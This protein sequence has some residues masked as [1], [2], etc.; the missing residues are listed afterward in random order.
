M[1]WNWRKRI[2]LGPFRINLSK[3][4]LGYSVGVPGFRVGKDAVGRDYTQTSIPGSG[5]YRRDYPKAF[6]VKVKWMLMVLVLLLA[7]VLYLL[8]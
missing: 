7:F 1:A 4:G 5:M 8:R 6:S 2:N 3:K